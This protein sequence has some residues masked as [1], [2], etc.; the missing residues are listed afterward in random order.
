MVSMQ[1]VPVLLIAPVFSS[2]ACLWP[3]VRSLTAEDTFI[4][5]HQTTA[6]FVNVDLTTTVEGQCITLGC[7]PHI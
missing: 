3:V 1:A 7:N 2:S 6:P 4:L 5:F